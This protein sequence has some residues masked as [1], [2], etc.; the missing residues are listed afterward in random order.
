MRTTRLSIVVRCAALAALAIAITAC[1]A[2]QDKKQIDS[3]LGCHFD[4][5][6]VCEQAMSQPVNTGG[7]ITSNESYI[8]QNGPTTQWFM[9]PVKA[10]GG[11]EV[12]VNC[13]ANYSQKRIIYAYATPSGTVSQSDRNWLMQTGLC[14]E[15]GSTGVPSAPGVKPPKIAPTM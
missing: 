7:I 15:A 13:Q 3:E 2:R 8:A 1:A 12:D 5:M 10:P 9:A 14:V 6:K 4:A 11:S